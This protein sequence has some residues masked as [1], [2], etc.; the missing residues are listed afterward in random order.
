MRCLKARKR[1]L[2]T[3]YFDYLQPVEIKITFVIMDL[4]TT[5]TTPKG[6]GCGITVDWRTTNLT[7]PHQIALWRPYKK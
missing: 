3:H 7:D 2:I 1:L 5:S 4:F 6:T